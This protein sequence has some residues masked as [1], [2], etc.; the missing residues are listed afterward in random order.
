MQTL[1]PIR[2]TPQGALASPAVARN[3][4]PILAVLKAHLPARGRVLEIAAGSGEH[5][6]AFAGAL[7]GLDWTPS[8]PSPE[9]RASIASW[10][11]TADLANLRPPLALDV[12]DPTTWPAERMQ[13][14]VCINMVHIS[15]WAATEGLIALAGQLLGPGGLLVLYGPYREAETPLAPSNA[16]FD[17]SLKARDPAWG[18]RDRAEVEALARG[19]GLVP[20][21]RVEMPANNLMLLLRRV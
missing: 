15:P 12:L 3:T 10:A 13:A 8:D 6:V 18:L 5:A 2:A 16:A 21:L 4:A 9:A 1:D 14:V 19:E 11:Q 17:A 7:P 20:T